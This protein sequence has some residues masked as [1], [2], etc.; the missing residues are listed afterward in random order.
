MFEI[1]I[2]RLLCALQQRCDYLCS[3]GAGPDTL[4]QIGIECLGFYG[5]VFRQDVQVLQATIKE[6]RKRLTSRSAIELPLRAHE[7]GSRTALYD[8]I[9]EAMREY[10]LSLYREF[11]AQGGSPPT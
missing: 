5:A 9:I 3:L 4:E 11:R 6:L 2:R 8:C 7:R 1:Q 10:D